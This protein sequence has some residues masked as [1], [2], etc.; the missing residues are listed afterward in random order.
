MTTAPATS[1]HAFNSA[2]DG[3]A[4]GCGVALNFEGDAA[5]D[6]V[7]LLPRGPQLRGHDGRA[8]RI[9]NPDKLVEAFCARGLTLPVDINHATYLKGPKGDDAPA[10]GWIDALETRDGALFGRVAWNARG[11]EAIKGR[12]YRYVSPTFKFDRAGNVVELTGAGLVNTPNF[13]MPALNSEDR[14]PMK[15]LLKTLGLAETATEADAIAAVEQLRT[16]GNARVDLAHFVPRADLDQALNRASTAEA[17]LAAREKAAHDAAVEAAISDAVK[18][19]KIAPASK[20][21]YLATCASKDG[22]EKFVAFC[23]A[24]PSLFKVEIDPK[25]AN[26]EGGHALNA[27]ELEVIK[28][29]GLTQEQY[30]AARGVK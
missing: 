1:F 15:D 17:A 12:E 6:W 13:T 21:F 24:Q 20:D 25:T 2:A 5:P 18:G 22:L 9:D 26:P 19:G 27:A 8:W 29:S 30:L 16:A 4:F 14:T 28:A 7:Q 3:S 10:V 11:A 23:A